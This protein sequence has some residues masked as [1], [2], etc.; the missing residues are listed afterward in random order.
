MNIE[1]KTSE[2]L[3]LLTAKFFDLN[4][5]ADRIASLMQNEYAMPNASSEFHH[6]IAHAYPLIADRV[7]EIKDR[8]NMSSIYDQTHRDD[9]TYTNLEDMF[10]SFLNENIEAY[11]M[12]KLTYNIA[13]ENGDFNVQADLIGFMQMFNK[14]IAQIITLHDKAQQMPT[15]YARFDQYFDKFGIVGLE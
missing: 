1:P 15:E 11:S 4:R 6:K 14:I 8:W 12:I 9:R 13:C 5:S 2:A 7:T 10:N 3:D